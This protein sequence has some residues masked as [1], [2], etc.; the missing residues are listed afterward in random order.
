MNRA[1]TTAFTAGVCIAGALVLSGCQTWRESLTRD[2]RCDPVSA[3]IYFKPDSA[4]LG[5]EARGL[6]AATA[7]QAAGCT[8]EGVDVLGLADA[9]G[10]PAAN[11]TLS[12]ARA[13]TVAQALTEAGLPEAAFDTKAAGQLNAVRPDGVDR[14]MRRRVDIRLRL[15]SPD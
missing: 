8:V 9:T 5:P 6:I 15:S 14:P 4:T 12:Q 1:T 7:R 13:A 2:S 10:A 11:L 3:E